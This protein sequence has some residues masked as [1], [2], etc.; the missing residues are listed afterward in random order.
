MG[1]VLLSTDLLADYRR[2]SQQTFTV[3][4][5]ETT[6]YQ[7]PESRVIEISALK[8]S[9]QNG[10]QHQQTHLINPDVLIP[11]K[12]VQFTGISQSMIETAL[13][14]AEV[15]EQY[16]PMLNIGVLTGHNLEFDYS[17]IRF[18][19]E[20]LHVSCSRPADE[21]LCTVALSR[22]MLPD[23]PSRRLPDLVR[24]FGF[25]VGRSHRAAADTIACWLLAE[26]LLKEIQNEDDRVLLARFAQEWLP[27]RKA[28]ELLNCSTKIAQAR[29]ATAGFEPRVSRR[30]GALMYRRGAIESLITQDS[31]EQLSFF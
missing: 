19:Y 15:W 12:I 13:A 26:H 30:S 27:L 24:H 11:E 2:L 23:L 7:P 28:A 3:V 20:Q 18:E 6:G 25:K 14:P 21:Q 16:L 5:V 17:F 1:Y 10:I 8:A 9:L 4:D 29:L 22:L 31:G